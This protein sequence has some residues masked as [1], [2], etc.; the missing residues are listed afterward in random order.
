MDSFV[1]AAA[2]WSFV[3][4][5][6]RYGF[7]DIPWESWGSDEFEELLARGEKKIPVSV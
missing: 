7:S 1:S 5:S 2:E 4:F 3:S 6:S